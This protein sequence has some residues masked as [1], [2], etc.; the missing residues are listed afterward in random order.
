MSQCSPCHGSLSIHSLFNDLYFQ[1]MISLFKYLN[2]NSL[3]FFVLIEE[4][5][6]EIFNL[7]ICK[8]TLYASNLRQLS[9]NK[10]SCWFLTEKSITT[11][12][13][14][15]NWFWKNCAGADTGEGLREALRVLLGSPTRQEHRGL[16]D[17]HRYFYYTFALL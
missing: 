8:W 17:S 11:R 7:L 4:S 1:C 5:M 13:F 9:F 12:E 15:F 10:N 3:I 2:S 6:I 14:S 16:V